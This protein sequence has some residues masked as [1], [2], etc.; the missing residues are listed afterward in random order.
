MNEQFATDK[1]SHI[2]KHLSEN[3]RV[4]ASLSCKSSCNESCFG[5]IDYAS[6]AFILKV[7][8]ALHNNWL[9]PELHRQAGHVSKYHFSLTQFLYLLVFTHILLFT[10]FIS[11]TTFFLLIYR[12]H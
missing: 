1:K 7:K 5:F 11:I 3:P 4:Y 8:E 6:S 9:K 10:F 12:Q 2:L